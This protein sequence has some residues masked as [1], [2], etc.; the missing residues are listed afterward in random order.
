MRLLV[1]RRGFNLLELALAMSMLVAFMIL[2]H[3]TL[4]HGIGFVQQTDSYT[5]PQKEGAVLLRRIREELSNGHEKWV[6]LGSN[7][8]SI[9]FLSAQNPEPQ[10]PRLDFD[11]T[12]GRLF[13]KKWVCFLWQSTSQQV[14]RME[15]ALDSPTSNLTN[16]PD[17]S[18]LPD[19]FLTTSNVRQRRL[20]RG[21]VDFEILPSGPGKYTVRLT[22]QRLV[23]VSSRRSTPERVQ[24]HL[25]TTVA[26]LNQDF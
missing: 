10:A 18:P 25:E 9:R 20:A 2:T 8:A 24:V 3:M 1:N 26:I 12:N 4:F 15:L 5:Y 17:P 16:E 14:L 6:V 11:S 19:E 7:A 22:A 13:W 21:I 23:P